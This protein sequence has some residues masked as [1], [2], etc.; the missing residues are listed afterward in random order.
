MVPETYVIDKQAVI[1]YKQIGAV[2]DDV[3]TKTILSI[4]KELRIK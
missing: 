3:V 2:D 4:V 1:R